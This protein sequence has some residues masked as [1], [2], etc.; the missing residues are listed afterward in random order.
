M[1]ERLEN[2][3]RTYWTQRAHDFGAVRG[4]KR[5]KGGDG[6]RILRTPVVVEAS[7]QRG[8]R[9]RGKNQKGLSHGGIV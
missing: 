4:G 7:G 3:V 2:R 9:D 6:R 1:E 5:R 8:A